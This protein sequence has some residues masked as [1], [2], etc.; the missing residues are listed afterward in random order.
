MA[1]FALA[2]FGHAKPPSEIRQSMDHDNLVREV[3]LL[4]KDGKNTI[5]IED[6][7]E[8]SS[9]GKGDSTPCAEKSN[10]KKQTIGRKR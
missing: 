6:G 2:N 10:A 4:I 5:Q 8:T 3:T 7:R 1:Q 9:D